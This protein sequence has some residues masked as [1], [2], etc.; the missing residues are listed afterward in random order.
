[1]SAPRI[2]AKDYSGAIRF[3]RETLGLHPNTVRVV[4]SAGGLAGYGYTLHLAPGWKKNHAIHSINSR[5]RFKRGIEVIDHEAEVEKESTRKVETAPDIA[6]VEPDDKV[7]EMHHCDGCGEDY[8]ALSESHIGHQ[9]ETS[10][11]L[12][13]KPEMI[14]PPEGLPEDWQDVGYTTNE[15]I[16]KDADAVDDEVRQHQTPE[17][18]DDPTGTPEPSED[19]EG[20]EKPIQRRRRRCKKCGELVEPDDVEAHAAQHEEE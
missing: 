18:T 12:T 3:A 10:V 15:G 17:E 7:V 13:D 20:P 11:N 9:P 16:A 14:V 4:S 6:T 5:L 2:I 8:D 1:M 19:A